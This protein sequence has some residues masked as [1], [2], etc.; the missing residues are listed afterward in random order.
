MYTDGSLGFPEGSSFLAAPLPEDRI[1]M[2]VRHHRLEF[3]ADIGLQITTA[4]VPGVLRVPVTLTA[5]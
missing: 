3:S 5:P 2:P 1:Q 4:I